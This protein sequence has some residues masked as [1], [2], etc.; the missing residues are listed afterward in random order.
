MGG[1]ARDTGTNTASVR[2]FY[3]RWQEIEDQREAISEDLKE[4]FA[5]AK[6]QGF[7]TKALRAAFRIQRDD[8][9][10]ETFRKRVRHESD[11]ESYRL[12]LAGIAEDGPART[13]A[14]PAREDGEENVARESAFTPTDS[15]KNTEENG[16]EG[17]ALET[18]REDYSYD[19]ETGEITEIQESPSNRDGSTD[20]KA[21][22]PG[23]PQDYPDPPQAN[24]EA[25]A[26]EL[27]EPA[28]HE[29]RSATGAG[30]LAFAGI[31][32]PTNDELAIPDFLRRTD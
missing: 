26:V 12:A 23:I 21:W 1:D 14:T 22:E 13:P 17:I 18:P 31:P 2:S 5:E 29:G 16:A 25:G 10:A 4:L 15:A 30:K 32:A 27:S 6:E 8:A 24:A 28:G 9:D 11:L 3:A 20:G 19:P 7:N